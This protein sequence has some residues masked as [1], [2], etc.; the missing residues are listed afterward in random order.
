[1]LIDILPLINH[2]IRSEHETRLAGERASDWEVRV[3]TRKKKR[4]LLFLSLEIDYLRDIGIHIAG[5][6]TVAHAVSRPASQPIFFSWSFYRIDSDGKL[7][8]TPPTSTFAAFNYY[9][10]VVWL[11]GW[12]KKLCG[13]DDLKFL[14]ALS[15]TR[16]F[17]SARS[18]L[19]DGNRRNMGTSW[20]G[21]CR[22]LW[23]CAHVS[24]F[25]ESPFFDS[26]QLSQLS[27]LMLSRPMIC[28]AAAAARSVGTMETTQKLRSC[29]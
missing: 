7:V 21:C 15:S 12:L 17:S 4:T 6:N 11:A 24:V 1:M 18:D 25:L 5:G 26:R 19:R 20:L 14:L 9:Y 3:S 10:I 22:A 13:S 2:V 23:A 16:V 28:R 29:Y 27:W 8:F